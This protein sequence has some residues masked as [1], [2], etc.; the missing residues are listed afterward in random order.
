MKIS[1]SNTKVVK[2]NNGF[3]QTEV[4][5][6]P[7]DW[8]L[9]T[10]DEAFDFLTTA[11]YSRAQLTKNDEIKYIHYGDI[12]TKWNHFLDLNKNELPTIKLDQLRK[13][14]LLREGDLL[15]ADASEDYEGV[16]K[17]VEVRNISDLKIIS[18]LHTFL[19]R[20]NNGLLAN[21]FKGYIHSNKMVKKQ[22][23]TLA[24]GLKV[25]GV[26]KTNLKVIKIP[27]PPTK[28]EQIAIATALN[29]AEALITGLEKLIAKKRNIK[30]GAMQEL[31]RP[32]EGWVEKKLGDCLKQNPNYGINAAAVPYN[33]SLPVYLRITD[34][35]EDGKYSK[36]NIVSVDLF[37]S[38]S[39]YLE[40]GDLVF[41]RTGA[42]VG[43]TY[44]YNNRDGKLVFAGFL[45]RVKV[46]PDK[47]IP[48][49]FQ[50]YTQ[51]SAYW[52]WIRSNSMRT[53]Q[54]GING[55]EFKE[56][57]ISLPP[58]LKEQ[59]VICK[60]LIDMDA[61]IDSFEKKLE[62]YKMIKQGMMQNLL[63]GKIRL[64]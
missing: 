47:L 9:V 15:M 14:P 11:T 54:P 3:Q 49:Y 5:I 39:Y 62:K 27:L 33:E 55:N 41:A 56:L 7:K 10:Y 2:T 32:K 4:G 51:T 24:T 43:K 42:S 35:T 21:G 57:P 29:D 26:S 59:S 37:A 36:K 30:Q 13:Y 16:G 34:I 22:M 61:E 52:N 63:T 8:K 64:I 53:G 46:N 38:S 28:A 18:G 58:T 48:E 45:I 44:L 12:H 31:L 1:Q 25:Y 60:V 19:L 50:F 23:D 6:I 20:D 40:K 17:S